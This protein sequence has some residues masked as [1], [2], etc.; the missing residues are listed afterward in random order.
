MKQLF[1]R[2]L[3]SG[4]AL[5]VLAHWGNAAAASTKVDPQDQQCAAM[6]KAD[7]SGIPDAPTQIVEAKAIEAS[8]G[9]PAHCRVQG[10]V[11]PQVGFELRLPAADWNGKFMH[12]GCG[13]WCGRLNSAA[14]DNPL[15]RGYVCVVS[16]MGHKGTSM[17]LLWSHNN[18]QAQVDFG[19]RATHVATVAGK[20]IATRFYSRAPA[21][22]YFMGCST[23]GYQ[24]LAAAQRF[25]WDF[26]GIVAGA[27]DIDQTAASLRV[28]WII[29]SY[30]DDSGRPRLDA[31]DLQTLH[32]RVLAQC[33]GKDG[34]EDGI[35]G[36]PLGCRVDVK[37]L[38]CRGGE[39]KEC[40]DRSKLDVVERLYSGP[41][42][43]R[44]EL[45]V[46]GGYLPG[47]ELMWN[48]FWPASALEQFFKYG[49]P[50][51]SAGPQ[52]KLADLDFDNDPKRFGLAAHYE[53]SN[54]DLRRFKQAG[55]K[56]IVFHGTHD[57]IDPPA[58]VIDYYE[59]VEQTMGGRAATQEFFR[60]FM[61]PG[62]NHCAGG[63]GADV[64]DFL[65]P[66]EAWVERGQAPDMILTARLKEREK[67][68]PREIPADPSRVEFTRPVFPHPSWA[69]YKGTG[70]PKRAENFVAA[71]PASEVASDLVTHND[72]VINA[73]PADIWPRIVEPAAW[74]MGAEFHSVSGE[75]GKVGERF[76]A[77]MPNEPHKVAYYITNIELIPQRRRTIRISVAEEGLMGF[78][79]WE[80][81]PQGAA[82]QVRYD[83]Y[84]QSSVVEKPDATA[85]ERAAEARA[86]MDFNQRRFGDELVAL[87]ALIEGT[88]RGASLDHRN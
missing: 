5:G 74:K 45:I 44:G 19:Y 87:K 50:G 60:L 30:L 64:A 66:L 12:A 88:R 24:G 10:Y 26:D 25:P 77:V 47:S 36:N 8:E 59:T 28:A 18:L 23:G 81:V 53:N 71:S 38:E 17:D 14:C 69:R 57:T 9:T 67:T 48:Q 13:G 2:V 70:D 78:A 7:L 65:S 75:K 37:K 40:L 86:W 80:L 73:T 56:L 83:V 3:I 51:Y 63:D 79:I 16:D 52:W 21:R 4:V 42:T 22:S 1:A 58:P 35:V 72:V 54:P 68:A 39:Q 49:I 29:R 43:S 31:K 32:R 46:P 15:R 82:T 62:V 27:P 41:K 84:W 85:D 33:D 11:T 55:G 34:V 61:M 20:A 76:K 6:A